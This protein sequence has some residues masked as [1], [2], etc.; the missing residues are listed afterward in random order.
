MIKKWG[1]EIAFIIVA[2]L[3]VVWLTTYPP[4]RGREEDDEDDLWLHV[5]KSQKRDPES[6]QVF[7]SLQ[8]LS[9]LD[10]LKPQKPKPGILNWLFGIF[11]KP[12]K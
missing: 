7:I 8:Q 10:I 6:E 3:L 12:D 5:R 2:L 1:W 9:D 11:R 4:G